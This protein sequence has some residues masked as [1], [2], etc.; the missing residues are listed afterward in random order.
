MSCTNCGGLLEQTAFKEIS[1]EECID[2]F[3]CTICGRLGT[4]HV[5]PGDLANLETGVCK[6]VYE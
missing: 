1:N 4:L 6:G 5:R 2:T 3:E